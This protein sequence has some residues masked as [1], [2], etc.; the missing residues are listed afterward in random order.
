MEKEVITIVEKFIKR[1]EGNF[2][3]KKVIIY[4]EALIAPM[5]MIDSIDV[6]VIVNSLEEDY[7][8]DKLEMIQVAEQIDCRLDIELIDKNSDDPVEFVD[9]LLIRGHVIYS[10]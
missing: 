5:K 10:E 9:E 8:Q 3:L 1:L 7:V 6:A 2:D 4:G